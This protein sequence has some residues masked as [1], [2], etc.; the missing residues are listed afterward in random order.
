MLQRR[1]AL[2][3][4]ITCGCVPACRTR[5]TPGSSLWK[6]WKCSVQVIS[7]G[8]RG[9][10][11]LYNVQHLVKGMLTR[12]S[13]SQGNSICGETLPQGRV[14]TIWSHFVL[15]ESSWLRL[16]QIWEASGIFFFPKASVLKLKDSQEEICCIFYAF[17]I[18][19]LI[20]T[21]SLSLTHTL[22]LCSVYVC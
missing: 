10:L 16:W 9:R 22:S 14:G 11:D 21:H 7:S 5:I 12:L 6:L 1:A 3:V 2:D 15:R 20:V 4:F 8:T 13:I 19:K 18:M 17:K